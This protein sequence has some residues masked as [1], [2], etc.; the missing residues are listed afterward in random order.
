ML[1]I[2]LRKQL[3]EVFRGYF[4]DQK[5]NKARSK[6]VIILLFI[7]YGVLMFGV[8]GGMFTYLS[9]NLCTPLCEAGMGW[10]YFAL[11]G[12]LSI[13]LGVFGSV[14]STYA[15]LYLAK[16]NDLLL[17]MP[18]PPKY[19]IVARL[20][21]VYLLG[22]LYSM[23]VIVPAIIVY[24]VLRPI[25]VS[26][27]VGGLVLLLLI[28]LFV[29]LLSCLLGYV[30][31]RISL[32]LKNK[33]FVTVLL[34][35][36]FISLYYFFYFKAAEAMQDFIQNA[37]QYGEAIK[38]KA[39]PIYLFG[40]IGE[41]NWLA[42]L[43][44]AVV[45]LVACALIWILMQKSFL[46][47]STSAGSVSKAVYREK[48][49][50]R[51]SVSAALLSRELHRFTS[52]A[53]YM[54]N[55]G[56]GCLL[57][58]A[59]GIFLIIKGGFFVE[60]LDEVFGM[61]PGAIGVLMCAFVCLCNTMNDMA[62]PSVSLEG[63]S[64]WIAQSLPVSP[65]KVLCAKLNLQLLLSGIPTFFCAVV[66]ACL[67]CRGDI[68]SWL[69]LVLVPTV[70]AVFFAL[71]CLF[72]GL[73]M[74]NL[75]WTNETYPIKQSAS[76]MIVL[77]GGWIFAAAIGLLFMLLLYDLGLKLYLSLALAVLVLLS[78]LLALWLKKKGT[79]IFAAL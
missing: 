4:Y 51:R 30:V 32:K 1:K 39:Y 59:A 54:L 52:S 48:K 72:M 27:I 45:I 63:K 70:F 77:F 56:L 23:V 9:Y 44:F 25:S 75:T 61:M 6:G 20:L 10:L 36:A 38:G 35:L 78:A 3:T 19:I 47:I 65:W 21:N 67:C 41:G 66:V 74:P 31:A 58:I 16:D 76:I 50:V 18:I 8:L 49:A 62:A 26:I 42:M 43:I 22:L 79:R 12:I 53:N 73:K 7:L 15:S 13:F 71:F 55:C 17:S 34:S 40:R 60:R 29:L 37:V 69:L 64:I 14:F 2:L 5:K 28:S 24:W 57:L 11:T 46:K 33:S 68:L